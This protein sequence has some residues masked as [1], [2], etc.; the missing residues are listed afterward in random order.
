MADKPKYD[1]SQFLVKINIKAAPSKVYKAW[2]NPKMLNKWFTYDCELSLRKNGIFAMT[3]IYGNRW[4][5][6][7]LS[8]RKDRLFRFTFGNLGE[9]V[10]VKLGKKGRTTIVE[11]RQYNMKTT[12]RFK[13]DM[14]MGCRCGWTFFLANLKA[15]L[16]HGIDLRSHERE[17]GYNSHF[18]NS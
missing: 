4:E 1:W 2:T 6:K 17:M 5:M 12:P 9:E 11:L 15:F 10:E 7:V 18:V 16:E 14:H 8:F 13:W 3:D